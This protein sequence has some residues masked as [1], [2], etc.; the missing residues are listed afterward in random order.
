MKSLGIITIHRI[1]NYGSVFQAYALQQV[2][3]D[4]GY[5]TEIIDYRYP[6]VQHQNNRFATMGNSQSNEP[7]LQVVINFGIRVIVMV[8]RLFSFILLRM[9]H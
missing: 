1:F 5:R 4:L 6:N 9:M 7:K 8:I 2:C 3:E